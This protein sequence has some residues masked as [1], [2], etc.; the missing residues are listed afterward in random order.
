MKNNTEILEQI[1]HE[2]I[3]SCQAL[4]DEPLHSS[5]IMGRMA[6]AAQLGGAKGIRAN[7]VEDIEEIK[8]VVPLPIIGIMKTEYAG[9]DVFITPTMKEVKA[10]VDV[11]ADIIALDATCRIRP[12]KQTIKECF[13]IIREKFP[14]QLFMADCSTYEDGMLAY[15]LGF[16]LVGTTMCG[17]TKETEAIELPHFNLIEKLA[18][19]LPIPIIA[20]GGIWTP[21]D[22]SRAFQ[23]GAYAAVVGTA[24]T[25]PKEITERFAASLQDWKNHDLKSL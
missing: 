23:C 16:D 14:N 5:F 2:L 4:P 25:R 1:K 3:V 12:D 15:E 8:N 24:I 17:Y 6:K 9:S 20:E 21:E 18:N 19:N 13:P 22:L 7:S 10:L 11:G